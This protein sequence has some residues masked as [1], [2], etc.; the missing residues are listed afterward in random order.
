MAQQ[1]ISSSDIE[2]VA[3]TAIT[4]NIVSSQITSVANTQLTG[5]VTS[6]QL[7]STAQYMGFKNR[8]IN[9][10]MSI[11]QRNAGASITPTDGQ[12]S[13]DRW[14]NGLT[15]ASKY[16]VQQVT[17]APS[18]FSNSLLFT[19]LSAYTIVAGS[20]FEIFQP[21]EGFNFYDMAWGTA[22]AKTVTLSFWVKS[23]LTGTFGGS[24]ANGANYSYP[25]SYTISSANT[26]EQKSVTIAGPTGGTWVGATNGTYLQLFISLGA[27]SSNIGTAGAWTGSFLKGATGQ[28][29]LVATNGATLNLTGVQ[30][31]VGS[32]ATS[33][34]FRDYGRELILCQRYYYKLGPAT[35]MD[36]P[37]CNA[38]CYNTTLA[39]GVLPLPVEMRAFPTVSF[40]SATTLRLLTGNNGF[41][42]TASAGSNTLK[43]A[44]EIAGT[45][46]SLTLGYSGWFR[47]SAAGDFIAMSAEL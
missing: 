24:I 30:L 15:A 19:S 1:K 38:A 35:G 11:D 4:G 13:V 12:F 36:Q 40:T 9:G 29:N 39:F 2:S 28:T 5:V 23:S 8:I 34:D 18:G 46:A 32:Q 43:T 45:Y 44:V 26:W 37:F 27:G 22:S 41:S 17:D 14:K 6:S 42:S 25:F 31:E 3:N 7:A 16:S 10:G 20:E 33:F 21:V 47:S